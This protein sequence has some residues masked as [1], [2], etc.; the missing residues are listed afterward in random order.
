[1][2]SQVMSLLINGA[3]LV[4]LAC[5]CVIDW[6]T[7]TIPDSLW[8]ALA[9]LGVFRVGCGYV[10][11][12]GDPIPVTVIDA[13]IGALAASIPLFVLAYS[14]GGFGGGDIKL[15]FAAGI[16]LGWQPVILALLIGIALGA[17]VAIVLLATKRATR[18]TAIAFG[19]YLAMGIAAAAFWGSTIIEGYFALL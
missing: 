18:K 8:I 7:K 19:P 15:I 2:S 17:L 13:T 5:V 3:L 16:F 6:R 10:G 14:T 1:M 4:I 11:L 9:L 12:L